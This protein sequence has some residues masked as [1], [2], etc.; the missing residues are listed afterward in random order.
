[1][2]ERKQFDAFTRYI[3]GE[4]GVVASV[5]VR[6]SLCGSGN[7]TTGN[8]AAARHAQPPIRN[9]SIGYLTIMTSGEKVTSYRKLHRLVIVRC[10]QSYR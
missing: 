6:G 5:D 4:E 8:R 10:A 7:R 3:S 2:V 1:M 9:F